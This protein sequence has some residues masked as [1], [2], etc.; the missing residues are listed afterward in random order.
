MFD[1]GQSGSAMIIGSCADS[2]C[3]PVGLYCYIPVG[4]GNSVQVPQPLG[5]PAPFITY[6]TQPFK[7]YQYQS[8]IGEYSYTGTTQVYGYPNSDLCGY[9]YLYLKCPNI[10]VAS[11]SGSHIPETHAN[12]MFMPQELVV[13]YPVTASPHTAIE[14]S[15]TCFNFSGSVT[16]SG[17][18]AVVSA[19]SVMARLGC[20]DYYCSGSYATGNSW[21]YEDVDSGLAVGVKFEHLDQGIPA[22]AVA[23]EKIDSGPTDLPGERKVT[24][25]SNPSIFLFTAASAIQYLV[26]VGMFGKVKRLLIER[27]SE[28][29]FVEMGVYTQHTITVAAGDKVSLNVQDFCGLLPVQY[30]GLS[31]LTSWQPIV[32]TPRL[33]HSLPVNLASPKVIKGLGFCGYTDRGPYAYYGTLPVSTSMVGLVNPDS[34]VT[35][36]SNGTEYLLVN[37]YNTG[38]LQSRLPGNLVPYAGNSLNGDLLFN[39]Y[40]TRSIAGAHGEMDV[41]FNT[42]G[43]MPSYL[44]T[45]YRTLQ[46]NGASAYRKDSQPGDTTRNAY[47][48]DSTLSAVDGRPPSKYLSPGGQIYSIRNSEDTVILD[49]TVLTKQGLDYGLAYVILPHQSFSVSSSACRSWALRTSCISKVSLRDGTVLHSMA[50]TPITF[51]NRKCA[52][53]SPSSGSAT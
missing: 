46:L 36:A 43:T 30:C 31:T 11:V 8:F 38:D 40:A 34:V 42:D 32:P 6:G 23:P 3:G 17:S 29:I 10:P 7:C 28:Q 41:W 14:Y 48:C 18:Y 26:S 33:Y 9:S 44:K 22:F 4:G 24:F 49:G 1:Y 50:I 25:T 47:R 2:A 15:D 12:A 20:Q 19:G 53:L 5:Y 45:G 51:L 16:S 37:A 21:V 35:V 13:V 39:F 52:G 27:G